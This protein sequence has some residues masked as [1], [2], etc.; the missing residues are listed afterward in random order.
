M[1]APVP[2]HAPDGS[3][4]WDSRRLASLI[5][6]VGEAGLRDILRL[7][8]ADIAL[9]QRQ[10]AAAAASG[11]EDQARSVLDTVRG[12]ATALGLSALESLAQQ[13]CAQPLAPDTAGR[14]AQEI[15]RVRFIPP[16]K[17]AS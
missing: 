13:L 4:I 12:S 10:L 11:A 7:F 16:L 15:A 3:D 17:Q 5:A 6:D 9:M 14:L 1:T 8:L 2:P